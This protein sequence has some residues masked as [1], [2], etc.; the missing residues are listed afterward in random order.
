MA[1]SNPGI[2]AD[3]TGVRM[4]DWLNINQYLIDLSH[5]NSAVVNASEAAFLWNFT[6]Q[7]NTIGQYAGNAN[8]VR[9]A[10]W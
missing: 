10:R 5:T 8:A 9:V 2:G 1:E 3:W 6:M 7:L 4:M